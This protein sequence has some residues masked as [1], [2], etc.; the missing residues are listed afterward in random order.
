MPTLAAGSRDPLEAQIARAHD[1]VVVEEW[2]PARYG[3]APRIR[4]G[5]R[6]FNVLWLLP[7]GFVALILALGVAIELR[8]LP[9]VQEFIA[10]YPGQALGGTYEGFPLWLRLNHVFNLFLMA[11]IM[12]S[13]I[14]ILADHPRLY[15]N[16]DCTPGTEW[17]R[18][19]HAVPKGA[20]L[21]E[22]TPSFV[23]WTAKD[24]AVTI[25]RWLGVPG[26]RHSIGLARWIHFSLDMLWVINGVV[27]YVLL[28]TTNQWQRL[29]PRS[30]DVFPNAL[31]M[32][33]QYLMLAPPPTDAWVHYNALQQLAYFTTVFIAAPAA[34]FFG[35]MQAPAIANKFGFLGKLVNRQVARSI[36]FFI[37]LY[38]VG[39]IVVHVSLV[40]IT[41]MRKNLNHIALGTDAVNWDGTI[42]AFIALALLAVLWVRASPFTIKHARLVQRTGRFLIG[43][44]KGL[45]EYWDPK[46][47]YSEKDI[48]PYLWPNGLLP[49][50]AEFKELADGGYQAYK[51]RVYGLV[52]KP[53]EFSLAQLKAMP[54][55]EQITVHYCIQGWSGVA[56]WAGVPM[57]HILELVKPTA[58]ARYAVFYSFDEGGDGG[59]Y[60]DAHKMENMKHKLTIL[61]YEMNGRVLSL[62]HGAPLRLRCENE[63]GFKHVKWVRAIEFV[64]DFSRIGSGQG[65]YNEDHEFYGYR[66]PI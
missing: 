21:G 18:F 11:F 49:T 59:M 47:Q 26:L 37:L 39:F 42:I 30:W 64:D 36:H 8:S 34:I 17:F 66:M 25:P 56:K 57:R 12:R 24:D 61:A 27:Y 51:L 29:V 20:T 50:S 6:W 38:F 35:L 28:F 62:V 65:G 60:Y 2:A 16:R 22:G 63:L 58:A 55:Q 52:D 7:I 10:R 48:S 41:G 19:Q 31:S 9:A 23:L 46:T 13:G 53:Q 54:K 5:K 15:F 4:I 14:Q 45:V 33:L 43:W 40:F 32:A 44:F 1:E 3:T